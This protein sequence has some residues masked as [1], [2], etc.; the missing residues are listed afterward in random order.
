MNGRNKL[1]PRV[2][3]LAT[4]ELLRSAY[5]LFSYICLSNICLNLKFMFVCSHFHLLFSSRFFFS[6][7]Q[8]LSL[9][10]YF[11]HLFI[12]FFFP[13]YCLFHFHIKRRNKTNQ[14]RKKIFALK[15]I[16]AGGIL[17]NDAEFRI[18]HTRS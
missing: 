5:F 16:F 12:S 4:I 10:V 17:G 13:C 11:Y 8:P 7:F 6:L 1:Y 9:S 3:Y 14:N 2:F 15:Y 18:S